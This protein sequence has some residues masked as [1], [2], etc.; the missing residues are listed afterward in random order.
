MEKIEFMM[1]GLRD[2][3]EVLNS[4]IAEEPFGSADYFALTSK[5]D[6]YKQQ[7]IVFERVL[8][9]MDVIIL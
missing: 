3:I 6:E 9:R 4:Q 7:L 1:K 2:L 5:R 8:D